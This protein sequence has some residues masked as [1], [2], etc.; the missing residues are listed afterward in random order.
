MPT[1]KHR[2]LADLC[3][4]VKTVVD[5]LSGFG[6][7]ALVVPLTSFEAVVARVAAIVKYPVALVI[8]GGAEYAE[9][10]GA[11]QRPREV[12]INVLIVSDY[13]A[14][15]DQGAA[16]ILALVDAVETAF[17]PTAAAPV[18][19]KTINGVVYRPAGHEPVAIGS[20]RCAYNVRL[21][22]YDPMQLRS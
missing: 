15:D 7:A 14:A 10:E 6:Q 3:A 22:T 18:T 16:A 2:A 17:L 13:S 20:D 11:R 19:P 4:D 1:L 21:S 12:A 5:G 8:A 9:A